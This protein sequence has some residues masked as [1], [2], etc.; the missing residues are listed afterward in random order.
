MGLSFNA[1]VC[2]DYQVTMPAGA[3][4][5]CFQ[6]VWREVNV[7]RGPINIRGV[8]QA[9]QLPELPTHGC[10]VVWL[11]GA[12]MRAGA[13][14]AFRRGTL[15]PFGRRWHRSNTTRSVPVICCFTAADK[16][17][18]EVIEIIKKLGETCPGFKAPTELLLIGAPDMPWACVQL[19]VEAD[20]GMATDMSVCSQTLLDALAKSPAVLADG[21]ILPVSPNDISE[22]FIAPGMTVDHTIAPRRGIVGIDPRATPAARFTATC[23]QWAAKHI[24][25][26]P[27]FVRYISHQYPTAAVVFLPFEQGVLPTAGLPIGRGMW[28]DDVLADAVCWRVWLAQTE[29]AAHVTILP[30]DWL[31]LPNVAPV[32]GYDIETARTY[33]Y[34]DVFELLETVATRLGLASNPPDIPAS[35]TR[36]RAVDDVCLKWSARTT[37]PAPFVVERVR[38]LMAE[39]AKTELIQTLSMRTSRSSEAP[40]VSDMVH[41]KHANG[42]A[43]DA[44]RRQEIAKILAVLLPTASKMRHARAALV[45]MLE[46]K[47]IADPLRYVNVDRLPTSVPNLRQ[48]LTVVVQNADDLAMFCTLYGRVQRGTESATTPPDP[49]VPWQRVTDL[50]DNTGVSTTVHDVHVEFHTYVR[51]DVNTPHGSITFPARAIGP[52]HSYN[53]GVRGLNSI[54][55]NTTP[56]ALF[57]HMSRYENKIHPSAWLPRRAFGVYCSIAGPG[58]T[59]ADIALVLCPPSQ[60]LTSIQRAELVY[61]MET[62][63]RTAELRTRVDAARVKTGPVSLG[64]VSGKTKKK[65]TN[66]MFTIYGRTVAHNACPFSIQA[67]EAVRDADVSFQFFE[68]PGVARG[69]LPPAVRDA[70]T[71]AGHTTV[72]I[73]LQDGVFIGGFSALRAALDGLQ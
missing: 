71:R 56:V 20:G 22:R 24:P 63:K 33:M 59:P 60:M 42:R 36:G 53:C 62:A 17:K 52:G 9:R 35:R 41:G 58:V 25:D 10:A 73:V 27:A 4:A 57:F 43:T 13:S 12:S 70:V 69:S 72:P 31:D 61:D 64:G 19:A 50:R 37:G 23:D 11:I 54:P 40:F 39:C 34:G 15:E 21:T 55:L 3:A 28:P 29:L 49:V 30:S 45:H 2:L 26:M 68:I 44:Y 1:I 48:V 38:T 46:H 32:C 6:K 65:R 47:T 14:L 66:A 51:L 5:S 8:A 7:S 16:C 18:P 67:V